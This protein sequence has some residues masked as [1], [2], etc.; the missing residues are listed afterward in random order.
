MR[1]FFAIIFS[2]QAVIFQKLVKS[3]IAKRDISIWGN[4]FVILRRDNGL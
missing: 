1:R 3:F 4:C 2:G